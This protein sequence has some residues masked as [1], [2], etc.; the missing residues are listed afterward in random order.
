MNKQ[1]TNNNG[2]CNPHT[3]NSIEGAQCLVPS[4]YIITFIVRGQLVINSDRY[5][6]ILNQQANGLV[7][8]DFN[9]FPPFL[10]V[11][12]SK[13]PFNLIYMYGQIKRDNQD[14]EPIAYTI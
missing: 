7:Y 12:L 11:K 8:K 9:T 2:I 1:T 5:L 3:I 4:S 14:Q 6:A 10:T 13:H